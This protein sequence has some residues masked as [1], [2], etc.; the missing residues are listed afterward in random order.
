[1]RPTALFLPEYTCENIS[2][3]HLHAALSNYLYDDD[4]DAAD[5]D[6]DNDDDDDDD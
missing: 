5:N 4:A 1:M 3:E 6:D 2:W